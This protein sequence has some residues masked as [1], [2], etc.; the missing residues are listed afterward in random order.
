MEAISFLDRISGVFRREKQV[1]PPVTNGIKAAEIPVGYSITNPN[2]ESG[3]ANT[4]KM[5]SQPLTALSGVDI[6]LN[7]IHL[8][9]QG[10]IQQIY[11]LSEYYTDKD[12]ILK[13]IIKG[14]YTQFATTEDYQL[15]SG[16]QDVINAYLRHYKAIDMESVMTSIFLQYFKFANVFVYV[17]DDGSINTYSPADCEILQG[18]INGTPQIRLNLESYVEAYNEYAD[19]EALSEFFKLIKNSMFSERITKAILAG[20]DSVVLAPTETFIMQDAKEDWNRYAI[21]MIVT[22]L[23]A[24]IKKDNMENYEEVLADLD[25]RG[26]IHVTYGNPDIKTPTELPSAPELQK[27]YGIFRDAMDN[28]IAVT[29][30]W[31]SAKFVLPEARDI[32]DEDKY[33]YQNQEIL[34]AGGISNLI[35]SGA[36]STSSNFASGQL[37]IKT[38]GIRINRARKKFADLMTKINYEI[39]GIIKEK[40]SINFE[41]E[42]VPEFGFLKYDIESEQKFQETCRQLWERG[43][44]SYKTMMKTHGFNAE[45]EQ[46]AV[47]SEENRLPIDKMENNG[48]SSS[49]TNENVG[50]PELDTTERTS[51]PENSERGKQPKPSNPDGS[52]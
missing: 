13:G 7:D 24:L 37:S 35:V 4:S 50:R 6:D 42:D 17:K 39:A 18:S 21:P 10:N 32:F 26:F 34:S 25:M 40:Y 1:R 31:A 27:I 48:N 30:H 43:A 52:L 44:L 41:E 23:N 28:G 47:E 16:N 12:P 5:F 8:D 36:S 14:A 20:D 33:A 29:N 45:L 19:E 22:C 46:K 49:E 11:S 38:A 2:G 51:D 3:E 15:Y 9:K